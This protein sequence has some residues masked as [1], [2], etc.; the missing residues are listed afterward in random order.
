MRERKRRQKEGEREGGREGEK[1]T[2]TPFDSASAEARTTRSA[3]PIALS[4]HFRSA[5]H[6]YLSFPLSLS[7][8]IKIN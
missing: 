7:L 6:R 1:A 5:S 3:S 4:D 8:A 2:D